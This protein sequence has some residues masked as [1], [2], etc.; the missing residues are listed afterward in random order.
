MTYARVGKDL[1]S[2]PRAIPPTD[3]VMV[4]ASG[5]SRTR[6]SEAATL[7][8][9]ATLILLHASGPRT[10]LLS[11]QPFEVDAMQR[12]LLDR[13]VKSDS[14]MVD[15]GSTRTAE[16]CDRAKR[17]FGAHSVTVVSQAE[18]VARAV[19]TCELLGLDANALIAQDFGGTPFLTYRLH[20][21]VALPL[22]W[23]ELNVGWFTDNVRSP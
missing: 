23:W 9:D 4:L 20:E 16:S 21:L 10:V 19:Y 1:Y 12:Y 15:D 17:V 2:D 5:A 6:P 14:I 13:G 3:F 7:R 11:G 22:A 18:H 8:L